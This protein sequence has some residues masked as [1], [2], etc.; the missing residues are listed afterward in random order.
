MNIGEIIII[1]AFIFYLGMGV[2]IWLEKTKR[3]IYY[4]DAEETEVQSKNQNHDD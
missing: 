1:S 3:T 2:G 4:E